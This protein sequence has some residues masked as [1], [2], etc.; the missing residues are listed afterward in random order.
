[1]NHKIYFLLPIIILVLFFCTAALCNFCSLP[2]ITGT[3]QQEEGEGKTGNGNSG[4]S[5][6]ENTQGT[7]D[8]NEKNPP[9]IDLQVYEGP[10]YS[11]EDDVMYYR[12]EAKITGNPSPRVSFSKD[13]SNGA[14][15]PLKVQV[16]LKEG[17]AYNLTATASNSEGQKTD[18]IMLGWDGVVEDQV[19]DDNGDDGQEIVD[20]EQDE[21]EGENMDEADGQDGEEDSEDMELD[22]GNFCIWFPTEI[23]QESGYFISGQ[24]GKYFYGEDLYIGDTGLSD[25]GPNRQCSGFIVYDI[26]VMQDVFAYD[27]H[28]E[29]NIKEKSGDPSFYD[30]FKVSV[31]LGDLMIEVFT[32]PGDNQGSFI[33]RSDFFTE[34]VNKILA[35]GQEKFEVYCD[36]MPYVSNRN[37][38][39]DGWVYEQSGV[40][41]SITQEIN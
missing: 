14:W 9:T 11:P 30:N 33:L 12:V 28:L 13:D 6:S 1:M 16:N 39:W 34:T 32:V 5:S 41:L 3:G 17:E 22:A 18:E 4:N 24:G 29:F 15:G 2:L 36:L 25:V 19:Q 26:S 10:V 35:S 7:S 8:S 38:V 23:T 40:L 20:E 31:F 27:A 37:N 21:G